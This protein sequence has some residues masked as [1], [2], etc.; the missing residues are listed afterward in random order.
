MFKNNCIILITALILFIPELIM[1]EN[2]DVEYIKKNYP[3]VYKK[4]FNE[5]KDAALKE[6]GKPDNII[7]GPGKEALKS[8]PV[9]VKKETT[10]IVT[11]AKKEESARKERLLKNW[12]RHNS[13]RYSDEFRKKLRFHVEAMYNYMR[14]T[15]NTEATIHKGSLKLTARKGRVTNYL[16]YNVR[17]QKIKT[18]S[19]GS[20]TIHINHLLEEIVRYDINRIVSGVAGF[21]YERDRD[22]L[23]EDKVIYFGG[24]GY[25]ILDD[26]KF[27]LHAMTVMGHQKEHYLSLVKDVMDLSDRT[28]TILYLYQTFRWNIFDWLSFFE[29]GRVIYEFEKTNR[30]Y[31]LDDSADIAYPTNR[32]NRYVIK[33]NA[34]LEFIINKYLSTVFQY[35]FD[36]DNNPWPTVRKT[37]TTFSTGIKIS[38]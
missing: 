7:D 37:D 17:D 6:L 3:D 13:L 26:E 25:D 19:D 4:I 8:Q 5:G 36:Y 32:K 21:L 1:A 11:T 28:N 33:A 12:W 2:M 23:L 29:G 10:P 15:G 18:V 31:L 14:E 20:V 34:G 30:Y 38:Y 22:S 9:E 35:N 27:I 16:T 24:L